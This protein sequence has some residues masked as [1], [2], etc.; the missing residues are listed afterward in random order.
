MNP[1]AL[2]LFAEGDGLFGNQLPIEEA[3]GLTH[4][5]RSEA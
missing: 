5:M 4:P 3:G 2:P 1:A